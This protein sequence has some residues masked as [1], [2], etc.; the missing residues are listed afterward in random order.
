MRSAGPKAASRSAAEGLKVERFASGAHPSALALCAAQRRRAGRRDQRAAASPT[1]DG[2]SMAWV[3]KM[4]MRWRRRRR[5]EPQP[6]HAAARHR[7]RRRRRDAVD[8]P[9]PVSTRR[10]AWRWSATTSMSPTPTRCCASPITTATRSITAPGTKVVDLPAGTL[11]HHWTKNIIAS[12]D[13]TKLYVTVGSNSN[14]GENGMDA[15]EG[16]AAICEID[17]GDR[18]S[19]RILPSG[20]RNPI[21]LALGARERRA[22]GRGQRARRA[23]QRSRP[24]LHDLG[25]GR[26]LLWLA[27]QLLR[28]ACRRA[29]EAAAARSRRQGDRAGLRARRAH[30]LARAGL[31]RRPRCCPSAIAAASSSASTARGTAIRRSGYKVIFVPFAGRHARRARRRTC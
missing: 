14:V 26:R 1:T 22:V 31:L 16:R 5:A 18:Q 12:R 21:G 20:L 25:E 29:R 24:R 2:P 6:H 23:R 4:V 15:E 13:G 11:N 19:H 10:S 27:L 9:Q 30:R 17:P 3:T 8:L 28:P 7:W